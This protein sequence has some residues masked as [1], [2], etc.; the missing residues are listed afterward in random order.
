MEQ[1]FT[2]FIANFYLCSIRKNPPKN[3]AKIHQIYCKH[4]TFFTWV[5][6]IFK[7]SKRFRF[8]PSFNNLNEIYIM[9][10][11]DLEVTEIVGTLQHFLRYKRK[12]KLTIIRTSMD[13]VEVWVTTFRAT[14]DTI[15]R[16][17][18]QTALS[19]LMVLLV[20]MAPF[21]ERQI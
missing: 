16:N 7:Y 8:A 17:E 14:L 1:K 4:K 2:K 18:T 6:M 15:V 10:F 11:S 3:G 13:H 12:K 20:P 5:Y 19:E 21:P 9:C